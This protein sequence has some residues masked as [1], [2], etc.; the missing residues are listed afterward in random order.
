RPAIVGD[1]EM[2]AAEAAEPALALAPLRTLAA[3]ADHGVMAAHMAFARHAQRRPLAHDVRRQRAA[4]LPA[5]RAPAEH[6]RIRRVRRDAKRHLAALART[7][8]LH[9][10]RIALDDILGKGSCN[11]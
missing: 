7:A 1:P 4:R 8:E 11:L 6:V 5:D 9:D 2:R 3:R 10:A